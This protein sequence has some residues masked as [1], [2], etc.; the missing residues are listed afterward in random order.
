MMILEDLIKT[1][2]N[3][4]FIKKII[5]LLLGMDLN[6]MKRK[7]DLIHKSLMFQKNLKPSQT[8]LN[9]TIKLVNFREKLM[10]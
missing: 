9:S 1:I 8:K 5:T 3:L 6:M 10:T 7:S 2:T 4:D